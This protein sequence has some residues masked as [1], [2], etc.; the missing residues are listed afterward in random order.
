MQAD[1]VP[2]HLLAKVSPNPTLP[3]GTDE[4]PVSGQRTVACSLEQLVHV[5]QGD[6]AAVVQE[7]LA[8]SQ[9]Q[10]S[11]GMAAFSPLQTPHM[12]WVGVGFHCQAVGGQPGPGAQ[13][14]QGFG[15]LQSGSSRIASFALVPLYCAPKVGHKI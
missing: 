8:Q 10:V 4:Y 7:G 2:G 6:I 3:I 15:K 13:L 5:L 9:H 14:E 12:P 11:A 1:A